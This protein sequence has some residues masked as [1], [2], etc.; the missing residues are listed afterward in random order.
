MGASI[1]VYAVTSPVNG[2]FGGALYAKMGGCSWIRQMLLSTFLLPSLVC[3][4]TF[5]INCI[6]IFYDVARTIPFGSIVSVSFC[7][8]KLLKSFAIN[9]AISR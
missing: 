9:I 3:S 5:L 6:A 1:F 2:Y 7:L 4:M 8:F